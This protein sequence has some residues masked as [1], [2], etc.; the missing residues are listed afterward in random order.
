MSHEL[1]VDLHRM[2]QKSPAHRMYFQRNDVAH[3][4][5]LAAISFSVSLDDSSGETDN[6]LYIP[7]AT[8]T[9]KT[10]L[11]SKTISSYDE[12]NPEDRN[13]NI[14]FA[15]LVVTSPSLD[16]EPR[17]VSRLLGLAQDRA[18][19]RSG[20]KRSNHRLISRLL[21]KAS[22]K[23]SVHEPVVRF[24]LPIS[25]D[26]SAS[27]E[28]DY[29]LLISSISSISLDIESSHS[30]EGGVHYSLSSIYLMGEQDF[31]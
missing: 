30:T 12:R 8:T 11:P 31:V 1:G 18:S 3:Q 26:S 14:L 28:D 23:L 16:L 27:L 4:A 9:I 25:D 2:D 13:T 21:P 17:H 24:V 6:I 29:N 5:L 15:N 10:T 20:K 22:I 19:T 7:M